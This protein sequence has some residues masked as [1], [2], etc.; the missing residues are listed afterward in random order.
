MGQYRMQKLNGQL[1]DEISKLLLHGDIKDPR[2]STFLSI[3]RVEI[4]TDLGYAKVFVS[5]MGSDKEKN[6]TLIG[7]RNSA[8]FIRQHLGKIIK[9]RKIPELTFVEDAN[10]DYAIRI[11]SILADMKSKGELD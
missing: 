3:N 8:G 1:R 5:V 7:L 4:T 10:L 9:I 6:D 11:E 2:V